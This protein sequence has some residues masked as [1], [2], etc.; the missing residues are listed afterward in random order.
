M[1]CHTKNWRLA[2]LI[3]LQLLA[4]CM[5]FSS[6]PVKAQ[7]TTGNL[8]NG[9]TLYNANC[10]GCHPSATSF[11][12]AFQNGG[13]AGGVITNATA[14]GMGGFAAAT[15]NSTQE[16]DLA[17]YISSITPA[18]G[19]QAIPHNT[20]TSLTIINMKLNVTSYSN[21]T[22]ITTGGSQ[23]RGSVPA[24]SSTISASKQPTIT[25]TP[26]TG[27]CGT[28][29]FTVQGTNASGTVKSSVRTITVSIADPS[30]PN[31][32]TSPSTASGTYNSSFSYSPTSTGGSVGSY[33]ISGNLPSGVTLNSTTGII[34]GTPTQAGTFSVTLFGRNCSNGS[35][36][37]QSSNR[38]ITITISQA[39]QAT[40]TANAASTTL[41]YLGTTTLSTTGGSGTG[42]V[43]YASN[44]GN[45]TIS[46]TALTAAGAGSCIVTATKAADTNYSSKT[47]TVSIT[48]NQASQSTLTASAAPSTLAYLATT[49][50]STTGGN[51]TGAVSY[52]SNNGNCTISGTTLTAAGV[53]SCTVTATKAADTNYTVKTGTVNIT[54]TQA[55]QATLTASAVSSTLTYLGTTTL[56]TTGGS[57]TGAVTFAS[58]NAN[59]TIS[60]T[61]L[62]AAAVGSCI[63]TAT[64]AADTNYTIKTGTVNITVNQAP[65]ATLIA[66]AVST[67]LTYL[68]TTTL[69]TSGGSGTGAV[70]FASSNGNCT[71][72]GTT[73]TAAGAGSCIV[74]ATKAADTN[75]LVTTGTVSITISQAAQAT[76]TASAASTTLTYLGTTSLSTSGGNGTGAVSYA[77]NNGNCTISG[78]T[79]TAAGAG[80]C[81]VTA[82]KAADTNYTAKTGTV[83]ITINQAAQASLTASAVSTTLTYLGTTTLSTT[84]GNGTGA[85]SYASNNG[86]CTISGT[87]LTA[88]G[89]GSCIVT[90]TKAAD[91]NY[92]ATTATVSI[93]IN[94]AAQSTLTASAASTTLTYLGTTTLSTTGGNGTGAVSYASN[95]GNC[96]ISGTTLTAAGAGSCIVTATKAADTNYTAKT[97]TVTITINPAAQGTLTANAAATTL[98]YLGTTSLSTTGGSGT[99]AVSYASNNGNCTISGTTLTAAGAGSCVVTATKAADTNYTVKTGTVNIT[100]NQAGQSTLIA[101]AGSTALIYLATTTLS[102]SG[103]LGTGVVS[104]ASNNG[105]CAISGTTL[106]A[107][108][109]GS[110]IVTATKAADTNYTAT[111]ATVTITI[112]QATQA[113][114]IP[115]A[116]STTLNYL[117]TTTLSTM[118]GS[119]SGAVSYASNN[120]NCAISGTTL[121]GAGVGSCI[122]T[123]SKAADTNY[124]ATSGTVSITINA[125]APG[126]PTIGTALPGDMEAAVAFTAPVSNGG[127]PITGYAA[128]C[129]PTGTG[130]NTVSPVIVATLTNGTLY[131]CSV[132]AINA[133]G[134]SVASG[135]SMFTPSATPTAPTFSSAGN[136]TFT[137]GTNGSFNVTATGVPSA[138]TF[139]LQTGSLPSGVAMTAGGVL[140]GT[141]AAATLG[142]YPVVFAASNTTGT[143]IQSFTL[144]VAGTA[145]SITFT[146][147]STQTF[148]SAPVAL[149]A[150]ATSALTVT[151]TTIPAISTVCAISGSDVILQAAGTCT[152]AADQSGNTTFAAAPQVIQTFAINPANQAAL[153]ANAA[154]GTLTYLG[155]TTLSTTGGSGTG[156]VTF[157]VTTNPG[158]CMISGVTLT[159]IGIGSCVVTATQAADSQ[160][161]STTAT[162]SITINQAAQATLTANAASTTLTYLDTTSLSTTGGSGTGA[163]SY[164]SNNGNCTIS[165][166]TLT[167]ASVGSCIITATQAADTNYLVASATVSIT[168]NRAPQATLIVNAS[169]TTLPYLGNATLSTIGGTGTGAVS[170][171]S[172][173]GNC[174]ISGT[175]VTATGGG[176]CIVTATQAADANYL[177]ATATVNITIDQIA[178]AALTANAASTTLTYL[179]S[180]ALSTTGGT[181]TGAVSYVSDNGNCS[182]SGATLT[183]TGAGSCIVTA[184][185]AADAN[186]LAAFATVMITIIPAVQA[187]LIANAISTTIT[188]LGT[189]NLGTTGGSGTGAVS[190]ISNNGNC[191]IVGATLTGNDVGSCVVTATKAADTNYGSATA[192]VTITINQA[193]QATL[194]TNA[195]STTI[196]YLGTATLSTSGGSGTGAV[197]YASNNGNCT[198]SGATLTAATVGSCIVTATKAG[199]TN[200][201][202]ATGTV[203][204]TIIQAAQTPLIANAAST[205]LT[206][207]GTTTLSTIGGSGTG[208]VSYASSNG[209][210]TIAGA[211][212]TATGGGSCV[213]TATKAADTNHLAA[214]GTVS[215]TINQAAQA[216][217]TASAASTTLPYLGTTTLSTTGG[218]GSGVVSYASSNG[219]CTISGT[220]LTATGVGSCIVTAT[221]VADANYLAASGNIG[222]TID[223]AAQA[224][225]TAN[226]GST[227]LG[228]L[229]T[230][231]LSTIGGSGAGAVSFASNSSNCTISGTTLTGAALG[232]CVVTATKA[233]DTNYLPA[234]ATVNIT[235]NPGAQA[236]LTVNAAST[237]LIYLGTTTLSTTGGSGVG[238]VTYA[239]TTNPAKCAISGQTLT[240]TGVGSCIV[241]ATKA[242]DA[243]FNAATGTVAITINPALPG[244]PTIGT[245]APGNGQASIAFFAPFDTGGGTITSYNAT[246]NPGALTNTNA[247]S[248]IVV[249]GLTNNSVYACSVTATN[250]AGTGSASATV[251]V[252]PTASTGPANWNTIC[253][254]CHTPLPSGLQLNGAGTT[255]T[256]ISNVRSIVPQMMANPAV[257]SLTNAELND[258]AA[259]IADQV[260]VLTPLVPMNTPTPIDVSSHITFHQYGFESVESVVMPLHGTLSAFTGTTVTYTPTAGYV[261]P[262]SFTY[263]GR[264]TTRAFIGDERTVTITVSAGSFLLTV[265]KPGT[266]N[267]AVT[268]T[269]FNCGSDCAKAFNAGTLVTL[270]A[271]PN[272]ASTFAG[273]SG[274]GSVSGNQCTITVNATSTVT[275]NFNAIIFPPDEPIIGTA[276]A[277]DTQASVSFAPPGFDGG[278]PITSYKATCSPGLISATGASS[279]ITVPGL[280]NGTTYTCSV[281]ATNTAGEGLASASVSVTPV[282]TLPPLAL[283]SVVSRKSHGAA[284][285]FDVIIDHTVL[286]GGLVSTE[287]RT[288][289]AGHTLLFRFN[290]PITAVGSVSVTDSANIA[291]GTASS[292]AS[293]NDVVVT[294]GNIADNKRVKVTL[295]S[296]N[297]STTPF[298]A[299]M[300]FL[301]GDVIGNRVV[302]SS[303]ISRVKARSGQTTDATNF[304][305]DLN[306]SGS[307]SASDISMVKARSGLTLPP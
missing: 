24:S 221:K 169:S 125:T 282:V 36:T 51:G 217:L 2:K 141:P 9:T 215:I 68:G 211:T 64:K 40:L 226:A 98:T 278:S 212:L 204:I 42:A 277:G 148:G 131:T 15:F 261:G 244:A 262:D 70:S 79:L 144:S 120:G 106:T 297:G 95:N 301:I 303:A 91:T 105:N 97:G 134:T 19:A 16:N 46:G 55:A 52:A 267:G 180:T 3:C 286:I 80:S 295:T 78:T 256:V 188:Y 31:I 210:C 281:T 287:P 265:S 162:V 7:T 72:S 50:L 111:T 205:T 38:Q 117:D 114:L 161:N 112:S 82:T 149:T 294:L 255:G 157:A 59:C 289:V 145:Q 156:T 6:L 21:F 193:A 66:T 168:I 76:L 200:Y 136:T 202:I 207:L 83:T 182:I 27:Q 231:T 34:S 44:N 153:T 280:I 54:V 4:A 248:P 26:T 230:T 154:S 96:T 227:T 77:S 139:V 22:S 102:T 275:A 225:L 39:S 172:D 28:D 298:A 290:I 233:A 288:N 276:I 223:Q 243:D 74:T 122:V 13:D 270:T 18:F 124:T 181:G 199:D 69:G 20:A 152:L 32:T 158:N 174:T 142:A 71:I 258:L 132:Q 241:T 186:Y 246:C 307:I 291:A 165:G 61:T 150:T 279:P 198:I 113:T 170:F 273:W 266:G 85:V 176:S 268:G 300:G 43:S 138:I 49:T 235:V 47:G 234:T 160:Y 75:Y 189:T 108:G 175:T 67:A 88:A 173:N 45:C 81:I 63:V 190:F 10:T 247:T 30:A 284:G 264:N 239:V 195:T 185:Q 197:N 245:A 8:A 53:G 99:G 62:T 33:A 253:T 218:S 251:S 146:G 11:Y 229:N 58:N 220:T 48:I 306:A 140:T 194:T 35:L 252:T 305:F 29:T 84:G 237:T 250:S 192:T 254:M 1:T 94:Q 159:A 89:V 213:V 249:S 187:T 101:S 260:P 208:A 137:V 292:V 25:Y 119:G 285:S 87:T 104:Y 57:G 302:N 201:L 126:A 272:A 184:T 123:A 283:A 56:S 238:A 73:L 242:A 206:H 151:F 100:I 128:T 196:A 293:G 103:G 179:G 143:T 214:S 127:S 41:T 219:N 183:A 257:Q 107:A 93:T 65:Q 224:T 130:S 296:V 37:G 109:V 203:T 167:A 299:S 222:I 135:M 191:T 269:G 5:F 92:T 17:A 110:C 129:T 115:S 171:A 147:P 116:V 12:I 60:G 23:S 178:Q 274:C 232:T 216:T 177:V 263:R 90:A 86:N 236:T 304:I 14:N 121:T 259:Y 166:T 155:T 240:G 228:I 118:G 209:N 271:A 163:V 164:A 133:I